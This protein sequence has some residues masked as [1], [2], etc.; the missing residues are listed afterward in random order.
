[1]PLGY[2]DVEWLNLN[3]QRA[4]PFSSSATRNDVTGAFTLPDS[5]LVALYLP[6]HAGLAV[7][8]AKFFV[9]RVTVVATGYNVAIGYDDGTTSPPIVAAAVIASSTLVR[10]GEY[11]LPGIG[12]FSDTVGKIVIG[13]TDEIAAQP[14]GEYLF[15]ASGGLLDTDCIRPMIRG[16]SSISVVNGQDVSPRIYGD[17]RLISGDNIRITITG[18]DIRID[19]V[20]GAQLDQS[21]V[22]AGDATLAPPVRTINGIPPDNNGDFRFVNSKCVNIEPDG[23]AALIFNNNC[24][25]PCCGC[26]ELES[27][28]AEVAHFGEEGVTLRNY[29]DRL[30][31][32]TD[33]FH[34]VVLGSRLSD[35]PC[36]T[37]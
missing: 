23:A 22:C 8:P 36:V 11:A 1:M 31:S 14:A 19:A 27:L 37:C 20:D 4:Y 5:F 26:I 10:Y 29:I 12:D 3:E 28:A 7:D 16:V 35:N 17:V 34:A 30:K 18:N 25:T 2:W 21:C 6:V 24:G 15:N 32:E 33:Q 13:S 9:A